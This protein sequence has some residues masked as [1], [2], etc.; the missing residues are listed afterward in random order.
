MS[1][2]RWSEERVAD[3]VARLRPAPR[4]WVEAAS[5]LPRVRVALDDLV[6]R[7]EA[8]AALRAEV[9][10]D[11]EAAL[12]REGVEPTPPAVATLRARLEP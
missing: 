10:A 6:Q 3:L 12:E 4:G 2:E 7:I 8:D 5:E 11:L 1:D 9:L